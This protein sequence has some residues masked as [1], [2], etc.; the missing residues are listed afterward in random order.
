MHLQRLGSIELGEARELLAGLVHARHQ[1]AH[2][3]LE[4]ADARIDRPLAD[5]VAEHADLPADLGHVV[6]RADRSVSMRCSIA[7]KRGASD[8]TTASRSAPRSLRSAMQ[9]PVAALDVGDAG[10]ERVDQLDE[11]LRL[12]GAVAAAPR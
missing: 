2:L 7:S 6:A 12:L 5:A 10:V 9:Q 8:T 1:L 3:R 11:V 4:L